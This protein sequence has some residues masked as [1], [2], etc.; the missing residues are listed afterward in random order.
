M[1]R[2]TCQR[3]TTWIPLLFVAGV[4]AMWGWR[5]Y[6]VSGLGQSGETVVQTLPQAIVIDAGHGGKD[7]GTVA[8]GFIEKNGTLAIARLLRE[9]LED[10]GH[11]VVMTRDGD[12]TLSLR[13]RSD[14]ANAEPR[15]LFVSVHLN[16]GPPGVSGLET[17][18]SAPKTIGATQVFEKSF[19]VGRGNLV[20]ERSKFLAEEVQSA[21]ISITGVKDRGAKNR[22]GLA[23]TRRSHC[24]SIL[25]ECGF[26]SNPDEAMRL[27]ADGYRQKIA[28]GLAEGIDRFLEKTD[29]DPTYGLTPKRD[30]VA[31]PAVA[32]R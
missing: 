11:R 7:G 15:K 30:K 23:V 6:I 32:E 14:L 10:R 18:Y 19:P 3:L 1:K 16:A 5:E 17:F 9:R 28:S 31:A 24:P 21:V 26:L 29:L 2:S 20:D 25:V 4:F 8:Q 27:A 22:P 13:Q 12:T